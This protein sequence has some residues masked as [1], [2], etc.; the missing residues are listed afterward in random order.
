[1][2]AV[3]LQ[4]ASG[5]DACVGNK[6]TPAL[7][8]TERHTPMSANGEKALRCEQKKTRVIK[9]NTFIGQV[10]ENDQNNHQRTVKSKSNFSFF[11]FSSGDMLTLL[12]PHIRIL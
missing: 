6:L 8:S 7:K 3:R 10:E 12:K 1:M 4:A 11:F 9:L 2:T 5:L